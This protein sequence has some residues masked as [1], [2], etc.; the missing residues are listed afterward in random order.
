MIKKS[1]D[2]GWRPSIS[3]LVSVSWLIFVILWLAFYASDY[4]W[5][6]NLAIILFSILIIFLFLA[7]MWAIWSLRMIPKKSWE[8]FKISGFRW[9]ILISI[10]LPFAA[11]IFLIIWFWYYGEPYSVWQNI[12]VLLVVLLAIGGILGSIW[13]RWS[14]KHGNEMKKFDKIGE[15]IGKKVEE[16]VEDKE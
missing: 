9:R 6:K 3:I 7:G 15:E 2:M 1:S 12:A 4:S 10:V 5:E 8:I 11:M 16:A 14:M 13:A